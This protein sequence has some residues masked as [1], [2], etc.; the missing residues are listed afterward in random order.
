LLEV[1]A[2]TNRLLCSI[3]NGAVKGK[4][5]KSGHGVVIDPALIPKL[6][7]EDKF[8]DESMDEA[9]ELIE[10][11][12][13]ADWHTIHSMRDGEGK[14]VAIPLTLRM[15]RGAAWNAIGWQLAL[16]AGQR[17]DGFDFETRFCDIYGTEREGF[18]RHVW[19]PLSRSAKSGKISVTMFNRPGITFRDFVVQAL[20]HMKVC[21]RKEGDTSG[22]IRF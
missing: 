15:A 4:K 8:F 6:L 14:E 20:K 13:H 19:S 21:Y 7:D 11:N 3:V 5:P 12:G 16:I 10:A 18:H 22:N 17:I 9:M 1:L 2:D